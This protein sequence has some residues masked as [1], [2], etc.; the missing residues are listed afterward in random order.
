MS[1]DG[2][3][4][5]A[6]DALVVANLSSVP[7]HL[8]LPLSVPLEEDERQHLLVDNKGGNVQRSGLVVTGP[9]EGCVTLKKKGAR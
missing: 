1:V 7:C 2:Y 3:D 4:R 6:G 5:G 8:L 9:K